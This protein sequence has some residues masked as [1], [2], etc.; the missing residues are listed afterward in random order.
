MNTFLILKK[1]IKDIFP[2]VDMEL[3]KWMKAALSIP[4]SE[5]SRQAICS[6]Q[7]KGFHARGGSAF[8]LYPKCA[9]E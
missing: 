7:K 4:D 3:D 6:I 9:S 5:L 8:S 2:L 1:Y